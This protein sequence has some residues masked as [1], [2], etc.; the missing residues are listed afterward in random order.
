[1]TYL[2]AYP[3]RDRAAIE[4]VMGSDLNT[5][6]NGLNADSI[7]VERNFKASPARVFPAWALEDAHGQRNVPGNDWETAK[8]ENDFR[9]GT[10]VYDMQLRGSDR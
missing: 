5:M 4:S 6:A 1:V 3:A 7:V 10:G 2:G 9:V 8:Y